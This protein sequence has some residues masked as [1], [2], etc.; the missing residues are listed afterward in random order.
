MK[1]KKTIILLLLIAIVGV[2]GLTLA[3]FAN[4]ASVE[5]TFNT[6]QYGTTVT[7]VF[8]SPD[9]WT[10]GTTTDKTLTVTNS[11]QVDEAVRVSYT[12][13]W[14]SKKGDDLSL[15]QGD[16][17]AAV[18]NWANV[19]DWTTVT[20]N[21]VEYRY[22]NYKL[23]PGETTSTLLNSVTFNSAITN[24]ANCVTT[25]DET[26]HTKTITCN[27]TGDGYDGATYKLTFTVETVQYDKYVD[28]WNTNINI[29]SM[30]PMNATI[31]ALK[32]NPTTVTN[33]IDGNIH[34][35][36]T[37]N[38][39]ATE[40]TPAL[41]DYRYIGN[42]PYNYV[43]FNCDD[44]NNQN[45]E[46]CE[47]WRIIGIFN[48]DDGTGNY[49][50][51]IKLVRGSGF[52]QTMAWDTKV[53][54]GCDG[55]GYGKNEWNGADLEVFLN[56]DYLTRSNTASSYGLKALAQSQI[57]DVKY[58]LGGSKADW[59]DNVPKFGSTEDMYN[60]ERGTTV[61]NQNGATRSTSWTGKVGL[62]YPSDYGY[63][64][65]K[66]VEE[67]CYGDP[68]KCSE[69]EPWGAPKTENI[70]YPTHGWI[71][72]SNNLEGQ[73]SSY[74]IWFSSPHTDGSSDVFG[75]GSF[76]YVFGGSAYGSC[77]VRP[78]VYLKSNIQITGGTGESTNPYTLSVN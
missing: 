31:L 13:S 54:E 16:N 26:T 69:K 2:V 24:D 29:V 74:A 27:S 55:N 72:N 76:G 11:G 57:G 73:T 38:H 9:N 42:E 50:Q 66:G 59:S 5:N 22:Y 33:Y 75:V 48:V 18:I 63:T 36:Y 34:E 17:R 28:A 45:E 14:T 15:T 10:P 30:K 60:W 7:E 52:A 37:F 61:Y 8:E 56:G 19:S 49:E 39:E 78:V 3:Y 51:R 65:S 43:Y 77:E 44:I 67:V 46:S 41:T 40:Q 1:N 25:T 35:M 6:K 47:V 21:G 53:C 23:A 64:Y 20:E 32:S 62:M 12:E 4:T 58:Y 71:Y 70:G 68:N